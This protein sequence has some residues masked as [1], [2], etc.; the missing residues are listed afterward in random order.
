MTF[1]FEIDLSRTIARCK[2]PGEP[3]AWERAG[4]DGFRTFDTKANKEAKKT[5]QQFLKL[6]NPNIDRN[7]EFG[8]F[9]CIFLFATNNK[10][11]DVD[12]LAK[13]IL[14]AC[15]GFVW[16][17][18]RQVVELYVRVERMPAADPETQIFI[19]RMPEGG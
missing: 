15:N 4:R 7:P 18:D 8:N 6:A 14:D 10:R 2:I 9:G 19:Y 1:K 11:S 13:L 16:K 3:H 17:D 5:I 12:N